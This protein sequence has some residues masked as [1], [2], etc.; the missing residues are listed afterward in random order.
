MSYMYM[1]GLYLIGAAFLG[2]ASGVNVA[3]GL[4]ELATGYSE[5]DSAK[6]I[7]YEEGS[8]I[9][10][11]EEIRSYAK[12]ENQRQKFLASVSFGLAGLTG[13]A[14][15]GLAREATNGREKDE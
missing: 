6:D 5:Y 10:N 13:A 7:I 1:T 3:V 15:Y 4:S 11:R 2:A 9:S 14:A 8:N 12:N